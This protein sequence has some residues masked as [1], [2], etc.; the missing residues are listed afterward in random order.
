VAVSFL[1]AIGMFGAIMFLPLF[2]Q[3]VQGNTATQSGVVLTPMMLPWSSP[4]FSRPDNLP[5]GTLLGY[6]GCRLGYCGS[7][8]L[9]L[10][11][12]NVQTTNDDVVR[13]MVVSG[14]GLGV[15]MPVF[16]IAAQNAFP[17]ASWEL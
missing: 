7:G 16:I 14:I 17:T 1:L 12:M 15:T 11:T 3:G 5:H 2:I 4:A 9:S 8:L 10:S 6:H 13:Y